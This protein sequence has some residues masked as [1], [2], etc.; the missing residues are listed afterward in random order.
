MTTVSKAGYLPAQAQHRF[1]GVSAEL[2]DNELVRVRMTN[3]ETSLTPSEVES[4]ALHLLR[5]SHR[6][7]II[8]LARAARS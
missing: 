8:G 7:K 2:G 4:F 1:W 5:A 3:E 6:A